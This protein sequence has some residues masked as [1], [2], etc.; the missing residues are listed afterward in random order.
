[1]GNKR[2]GNYKSG[3]GGKR[4]KTEGGGGYS[5]PDLQN[6]Q[7]GQSAILISCDAGKESRAA[8]ESIAFLREVILQEKIVGIERDKEKE[9]KEKKDEEITAPAPVASSNSSSTAV[10]SD[11]LLSELSE[12]RE[13]DGADQEDPSGYR[14]RAFWAQRRQTGFAI[15]QLY[16]C[17]FVCLTGFKDLLNSFG[18]QFD[19]VQLVSKAFAYIRKTNLAQTRFTYRMIPLQKVCFANPDDLVKVAEKVLED[20]IPKYSSEK[21]NLTVRLNRSCY[22]SNFFF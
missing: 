12:I 13:S 16:I 5:H 17:F 8:K 3:D 19:I 20:E 7:F 4:S 6:V 18:K 22:E 10:V 2:H 11:L 15:L 21:E 9:E 14:I 1:M